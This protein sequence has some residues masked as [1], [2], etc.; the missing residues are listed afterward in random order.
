MEG[1]E[2]LSAFWAVGEI[3]ACLLA[4]VSVRSVGLV[5]II[6]YISSHHLWIRIGCHVLT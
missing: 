1:G 5:Q 3:G 2:E 6:E 4:H